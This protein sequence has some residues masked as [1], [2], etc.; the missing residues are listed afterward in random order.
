MHSPYSEW[1]QAV[2]ESVEEYERGTGAIPYTARSE[3]SM[4]RSTDCG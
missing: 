4:S 1:Y 2:R 3:R